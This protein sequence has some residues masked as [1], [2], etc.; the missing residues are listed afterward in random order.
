VWSVPSSD[1]K[2]SN[3]DAED[4][5]ADNMLANRPHAIREKKLAAR[6][7]VFLKPFHFSKLKNIY[8]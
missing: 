4:S 6:N 1:G 5:R 2:C 3:P 7:T 8:T